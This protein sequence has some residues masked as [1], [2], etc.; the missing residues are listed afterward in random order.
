MLPTEI[1]EKGTNIYLNT[2]RGNITE[3]KILSEWMILDLPI[4]GRKYNLI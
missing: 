1:Q 3:N 4:R 2:G